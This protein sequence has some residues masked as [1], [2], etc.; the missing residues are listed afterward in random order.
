MKRIKRAPVFINCIGF[1]ILML[2]LAA[3]YEAL[4]DSDA[5]A[6]MMLSKLLKDTG[7]IM[8]DRW[9]YSTELRV[10][11]MQLL[12][13]FALYFFSDYK[14]A[15]LLAVFIYMVLL[16]GSFLFMMKAAGLFKAGMLA[17]AFL[18]FPFN[19]QYLIYLLVYM[20]YGVYL[21]FSFLVIGCLFM[22]LKCLDFETDRVLAKFKG[23]CRLKAILLIFLCAALCFTASLNS[24]RQ[25]MVLNIPLCVTGLILIVYEIYTGWKK[26]GHISLKG[27]IGL[28]FTAIS[29]FLSLASMCGVVASRIL[30]SDYF[31]S[32]KIYQWNSFQFYNLNNCLMDILNYFGWNEVKDIF[33][34]YGL[35]NLFSLSLIFITLYFTVKM[36]KGFKDINIYEKIFLLYTISGLGVLLFMYS[37]INMY[38][39]KYWL[40]LMQFVYTI[41]CIFLSRR[42][43]KRA[44]VLYGV[45]IVIL[46][47]GSINLFKECGMNEERS[48]YI[49]AERWL[50]DSGYSQGYANFWQ[51]NLFAELSS[52]KLDMYTMDEDVE[53]STQRLDELIAVKP[54]LQEKRH[55]EQLPDNKFFV[56]LSKQYFNLD[57]E[58]AS[59]LLSMPEYMIYSNNYVKIY[60]FDNM[61]EYKSAIQRKSSG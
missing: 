4:L 17:S 1:L 44:A 43:D 59:K 58:D 25:L 19:R 51:S 35:F 32:S 16:T 14:S 18:L 45:I 22:L 11:N 47:S 40:V 31:S 46:L 56:V 29:L 30:F 41:P 10:V 2:F 9:Y 21:V 38:Q 28:T 34:L 6:E 37:M 24:F 57:D 3:R 7:G 48:A 23:D 60:G 53:D 12:L 49:E 50:E 54:W 20:G 27:G 15:R 55:T 39:A 33:S 13:K 52:G 36:V 42:N 61:D 5:A 26:S 8:T